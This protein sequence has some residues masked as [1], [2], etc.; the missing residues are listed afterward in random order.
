VT[1]AVSVNATLAERL[2]IPLLLFTTPF[3]TSA[4]GTGAFFAI[5]SLA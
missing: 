5:A 1:A 3:S 4:S 2:D